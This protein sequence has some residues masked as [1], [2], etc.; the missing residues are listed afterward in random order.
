[1]ELNTNALL[2]I[3]R[4]L[5]LELWRISEFTRISDSVISWPVYHEYLYIPVPGE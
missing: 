1:M 4:T 2:D 5:L 3:G